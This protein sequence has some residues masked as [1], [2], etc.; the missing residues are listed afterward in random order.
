MAVIKTNMKKNNKTTV[1]MVTQ[2]IIIE[3]LNYTS[4]KTTEKISI[5]KIISYQV[6]N[7]HYLHNIKII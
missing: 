4:T 3:N 7:K 2:K 1:K 6:I 5:H